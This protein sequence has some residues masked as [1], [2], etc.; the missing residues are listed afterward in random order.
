MRDK[1]RKEQEEK[2]YRD[3][4]KKYKDYMYFRKQ[5]MTEAEYW[6]AKYYGEI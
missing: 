1:E 6:R 5:T 2:K 3:I 4:M